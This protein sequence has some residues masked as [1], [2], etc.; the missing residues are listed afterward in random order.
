MDNTSN[1]DNQL[2]EALDMLDSGKD[3]IQ[4]RTA[5]EQKGLEKENINYIIRLVDEF[6]IEGRK[7]KENIRW[8]RKKMIF[9][10]LFVAVAIVKAYL[11]ND[12]GYLY[13]A[14]GSLVA[15]PLAIGLYLIWNGYSNLNKWKHYEP[16]ID[17]S[18]LKLTRR[19]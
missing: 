12:L 9:G 17:D 2:N 4:I 13:T 5:L 19:L 7:V 14:Y 18:K 8:S 6:A 11:F 1:L 15:I 16:E 3:F 10:V